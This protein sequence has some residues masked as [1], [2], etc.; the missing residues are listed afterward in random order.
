[1]R[2][3]V[4]GAVVLLGAI[5][6][7]GKSR[8]NSSQSGTAVR[9]E[10]FSRACATDDDCVVVSFGETCGICTSS[11]AAIAKSAQASWQ[12]AYN[13]ARGNCPKD[14]VV[15]K[16]AP[17]YSV[18]RCNEQRVCTFIDCDDQRPVD[19]HHCAIDGGH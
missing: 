8:T 12:Q 1:M 16:C 6:C 3:R 10:G 9:D 18:S 15:G 17:H 4:V 2:R 14:N 13:T 7:G 11:N 19:E 5:A